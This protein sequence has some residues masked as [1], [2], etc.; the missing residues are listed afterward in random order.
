MNMGNSM[1]NTQKVTLLSEKING[2]TCQDQTSRQL[3]QECSSLVPSW[4]SPTDPLADDVT[5][6]LSVL[7]ASTKIN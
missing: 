6:V 2:L 3:S 5:G 4:P 1:L 7:P